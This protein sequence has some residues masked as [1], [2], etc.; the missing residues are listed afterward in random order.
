MSLTSEEQ[1]EAER[2][3]AGLHERG[4]IDRDRHND[5]APGVRV[6]HRGHQWPAAYREGTGVVVAITEKPDS[7]WS[8]S[9]G[10]P[11]VEMVVAF[12]KPTL[13]GMSRLST[14]AQYHVAVIESEAAW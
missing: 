3:L 13:P 6:R 9:W 10:K 1:V 11:D 4:Y 7:G 14:L 12:D 2:I 5:L 8:Q